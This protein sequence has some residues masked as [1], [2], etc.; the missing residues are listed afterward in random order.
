MF[1]EKISSKIEHAEPVHENSWLDSLHGGRARTVA[2]GILSALSFI[3]SIDT[4]EFKRE[5]PGEISEHLTQE[6]KIEKLT[7]LLGKEYIAR[8]LEAH[9]QAH[10]RERFH[11]TEP[12]TIN[13]YVGKAHT[14][15][16]HEVSPAD[17]EN[18]LFKGMPEHW[19]DGAVSGITQTDAHVKMSDLRNQLGSAK[20]Q[21][22]L[23]IFNKGTEH[24]RLL[25]E[26]KLLYSSNFDEII[27]HE[28]AH[29]HD[30]LSD[31]AM[32]TTER[33]NLLLRVVERV[34]APDRYKSA[35]V[36]GIIMSDAQTTLA[37]KA[38][39]YFA[40][41]SAAT[42]GGSP[43]EETP[44]GLQ[45]I[46]SEI[47]QSVIR[48]HDRNFDLTKLRTIRYTALGISASQL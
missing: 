14:S 22:V 15:V 35:Y 3:S 42:M 11:V 36:E 13:R 37:V 20:D 12:I 30:W 1:G 25:A 10:E 6:Q 24:I 26:T 23:G 7:Q 29:A 33:I 2:L 41:I 40:V 46:D 47:A 28:A 45:H 43:K 44:A 27:T 38:Q 31:N 18:L 39:E 21:T 16:S 4:T 5:K 9:K 34:Q 19:I 17:V 8:V 48:K 32:T